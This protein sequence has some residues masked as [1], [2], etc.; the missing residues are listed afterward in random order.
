MKIVGT[1]KNSFVDYK[2]NIAYVVF[3]ARC[4]M[5][6]WYCHNKEVMNGNEYLDE[7]EVLADIKSRVGFV[8][9]VVITGGEPTLQSDLKQFIIKVRQ[10]GLAVKLDSNG[11]NPDVIERLI[12]EGLIDNIAMD[13]KA[14]FEKYKSITNTDDDIESIKKSINLI[15]N[16]GIDYE[17]RTTMSPDLSAADIL[18]IAQYIE[19]AKL[20][21]LQQFVSHDNITKKVFAAHAPDYIRETAQKASQFVKTI[22]RGI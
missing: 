12:A 3:T 7:E 9:A 21:A 19:G 8:D 2:G 5:N 13:I 16:S 20:Y 6:C 10:L 4:N 14:P 15:R 11:K 18:K 1:Q 22:T 17:F